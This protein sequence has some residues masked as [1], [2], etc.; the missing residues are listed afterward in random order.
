MS[1]YLDHVIR[2]HKG[3]RCRAIHISHIRDSVPVTNNQTRLKLAHNRVKH[4]PRAKEIYLYFATK[5]LF[6]LSRQL[7]GF[8]VPGF[9]YFVRERDLLGV[10]LG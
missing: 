7:L 1:E 9:V 4:E 2:A 3:K 6:E 5:G 10:T 8:L